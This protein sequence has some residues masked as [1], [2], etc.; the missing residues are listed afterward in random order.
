[1]RADPEGTVRRTGVELDE[2]EWQALR[3]MDWT[4]SGRRTA[5]ESQ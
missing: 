3:S 5:G 2:D 4:A 1:M